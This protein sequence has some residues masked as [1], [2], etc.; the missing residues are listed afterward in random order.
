MYRW[1]ILS[2]TAYLIA[3]WTYLLNRTGCSAPDWGEAAQT[4]LES[5]FPQLVMSFILLTIERLT[6]LI[7]SCG[8][9]IE[10]SRCKI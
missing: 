1:L 7:L 6:P 2:L 8:F 10:F 4:A 5:I 3:H 9:N